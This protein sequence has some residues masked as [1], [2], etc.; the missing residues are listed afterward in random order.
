MG[1]ERYTL[2]E[3][4]TIMVKAISDAFPGK[5]WVTAEIN[6]IREN[7]AGHCYLELIEKDPKGDTILARSKAT[8]WAYT[9]RMLKPYFE[10]STGQP[11]GK[12]MMVLVEAGVE[13]HELYGLSLNI[14]DIDPV[15]TLGDLER[16]RALT[17]RKLE[18]KE[19][20]T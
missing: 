7:A 13:F 6:E 14:K 4:N 3:I 2:L 5:Y 8:I 12:G 15:Y 10:T 18:E 19:L 16:K 9:W 1:N 11:P 20:S 17:I